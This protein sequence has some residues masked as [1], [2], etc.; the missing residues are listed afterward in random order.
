MESA[1]VKTKA[2]PSMD[3]RSTKEILFHGRKD[4]LFSERPAK[5]LR[6]VNNT[7][8]VALPSEIW[9]GVFECE[10]LEQD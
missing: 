8:E 10:S 5:R 3:C 6:S 9:A 1:R 2:P 4:D 7:D